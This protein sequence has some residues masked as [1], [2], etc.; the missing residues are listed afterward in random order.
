MDNTNYNMD[1]NSKS[2]STHSPLSASHLSNTL[3][4]NASSS[5]TP[6]STN[7]ASDAST[8]T[9][10]TVI[11]SKKTEKKMRSKPAKILIID[12]NEKTRNIL[13]RRIA[14]FGH[15]AYQADSA[16][17]GFAL[18]KKKK[19][20]VML[21][22]LHMQGTNG[23]EMLCILKKDKQYKNIPIIM[24]S[25]NDDIDSIVQCLEN[26]AEDYLIKPFNQTLLKARLNSCIA[27][28][29]AHDKEQLYLAQIKNGQDQIISQEKMA[30][31]GNVANVMSH[32]LK[33]PLNLI[34]NFAE[35]CQDII[36]EI[37]DKA[38]AEFSSIP[39]DKKKFLSSRFNMMHVDLVKIEEHGKKADKIL[40]FMLDQTQISAGQLHPGNINSVIN[41]LLKGLKAS[42][43]DEI[44]WD[45]LRVSLDP[46]VTH[47]PIVV[48][49][50]S[51]AITNIIDNSIY[52]LKVKFP[53]LQQSIVSKSLVPDGAEVGDEADAL[54]KD[55]EVAG[56]SGEIEVGDEERK[57]EVID[58]E[59]LDGK[60]IEAVADDAAHDAVT[61]AMPN[62]DLT[63]LG[64][65]LQIT[66]V[67]NADNV[68]IEIYDNGIGIEEDFLDK[69][70]E[71]FSTTKP[72][73]AGSGLGLASLKELVINKH[74]GTL[75]VESQVGQYTKF[76][77]RIPK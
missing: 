56:E 36:E 6:S 1:Y 12:D 69:I 51:K 43:E 47:C 37:F 23:Y 27:K 44:N 62:E 61:L 42:Y 41:E 46:T 18:L 52:A 24:L 14:F 19:P 72:E 22:D 55:D 57:A 4:S 10:S 76:T 8:D 29:D 58:A 75:D 9:P 74:K 48:V 60:S 33:N 68:Q 25:S 5:S 17:K 59:G 70:F 31:I 53:Q 11:E 77:L 67:N 45:F 63:V 30:S 39:K 15:E 38:K 34:I 16:E 28:K 71:P 26:G 50:L 40:R 32:E 49:D 2:S 66:T 7:S 20:D 21:I 35:I 3:S 73:G 13:K 65:V 64:A 54:L